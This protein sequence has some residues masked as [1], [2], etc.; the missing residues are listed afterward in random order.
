[1]K[2]LQGE[3]DG[4]E[5]ADFALGLR[6]RAYRFDKYKTVKKNGDEADDSSPS[7]TIGVADF[8]AA[9]AASPAR[10]A[11]AEGVELARNSGQR[12]AERALSRSLR[13]TRGEPRRRSAS[14]SK[15]LMRR[16]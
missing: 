12:A 5:A 13:R 7:V 9:R 4:A 1:M 16:R 2:R 3:W 10:T 14:T 6:L 8:A 11:V 15:S